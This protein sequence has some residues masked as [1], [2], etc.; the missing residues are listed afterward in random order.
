MENP[1][2]DCLVKACCNKWKHCQELYEYDNKL[3]LDKTKTHLLVTV[4]KIKT[5]LSK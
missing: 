1:C 2:D 5:I 4:E 3:L